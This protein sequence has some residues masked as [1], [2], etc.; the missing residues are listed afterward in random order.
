[1]P[2]SGFARSIILS[3]HSAGAHLVAMTII[4]PELNVNARS[5][6]KGQLDT[7]F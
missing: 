4:S 5:L 1:M 6:V 2:F 3:G 7:Y